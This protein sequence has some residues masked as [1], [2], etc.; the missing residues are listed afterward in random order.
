MEEIL[1]EQSVEGVW[2]EDGFAIFGVD[3]NP[4]EPPVWIPKDRFEALFEKGGE[5]DASQ[6]QGSVTE[7][8]GSVRPGGEVGVRDGGQDQISEGA[9]G[10]GEGE[11]ER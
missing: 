3:G 11:E 9:T 1:I 10:E 6:E 2:V 8:G 5:T 4:I 7:G